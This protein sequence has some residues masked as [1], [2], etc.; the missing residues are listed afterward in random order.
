M[1]MS[2]VLGIAAWTRGLETIAGVAGQVTPPPIN[3]SAKPTLL[4][5]V[6]QP[7]DPPYRNTRND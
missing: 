1:A 2:A 6:D 5:K 3:T 4:P 7:E